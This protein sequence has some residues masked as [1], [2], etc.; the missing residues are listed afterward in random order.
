MSFVLDLNPMI[1]RLARRRS[2]FGRVY[3]DAD[4]N[5]FISVTTFLK[6]TTDKDEW[7]EQWRQRV[8]AEKAA[9][10]SSVAKNRGT[11]LHTAMETLLRGNEVKI[12]APDVRMLFNSLRGKIEENLTTIHGIELPLYSTELGMAGT[13]DCFGYWKGELACIDWKNSRKEKSRDQ[14]TEY[15]LQGVSYSLMY[16]A[17]YG[18]MPKK[19][20]IPIFVVDGQSVIYEANISEY[21]GEFDRRYE[22]FKEI[23]NEKK[24]VLGDY[25]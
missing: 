12:F 16:Y 13:A 10:I 22:N 19:I 1:G 4:K 5:I 17:R 20:V 6:M 3:E 14:I 25:E 23:L 7:L 15:F 2:N 21:L 9:Q 24:L 8:G 18:V 11:A